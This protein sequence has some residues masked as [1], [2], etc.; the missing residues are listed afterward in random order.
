MRHNSRQSFPS[1]VHIKVS[2]PRNGA[3]I[4]YVGDI[5]ESGVKILS[6]LPF[7]RDERMRIKIHSDGVAQFLL[8]AVC[9]WSDNHDEPE[10]F[11]GGFFLE[12]PPA[13]FISTVEKWRS[14]YNPGEYTRIDRVDSK[15]VS[16]SA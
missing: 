6:D 5:S 16:L 4:G 2:N 14:Q 10:Y 8:D 15:P 1:H 11:A 3:L 9:I 13:G 12:Q 7:V